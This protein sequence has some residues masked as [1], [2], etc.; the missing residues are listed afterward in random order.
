M[1][2]KQ[3][4]FNNTT[5]FINGIAKFRPDAFDLHFIF[6]DK[7][8]F[9][10]SE[11]KK[12][13]K[14]VFANATIMGC[15][16]AGEIDSQTV[17]EGSIVI[18]SIKFKNIKIIKKSYII[19]DSSHSK[20][21]GQYLAK[22]LLFTGLKHI[23]VLSDGINVNGTRLTEGINEMIGENINVSGGLAGDNG[24]FVKTYV[25]DDN[26]NFVSNCI[27]AIG[28]YEEDI[29]TST[30]AYGGWSSFGIERSITKSIENKVYE[31]DDKPALKL[32]KSYLGNLANYLPQSA[33]F[34][35]LELKE[36]KDSNP[37]VRTVLGVNKKEN[38]LT[39]AGNI[40]EGS[41][42][43]LMKTNF[44]H[45][46]NGAE[47]AAELLSNQMHL[48]ELIIVISCVGRK[49]VLKQLTQDEI[50]AIKNTIKNKLY[51]T[52]FYSYGEISK[53]P[54]SSFCELHNQ[55]MTLTGF[56]ETI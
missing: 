35:P 12:I 34:F 40:P 37:L 19:N 3:L 47:R 38:T 46:I 48:I 17:S 6:A 55:T 39:F 43:K 31:I 36:R 30:A 51:I 15:S 13:L 25:A 56:K 41:K 11:S 20:S 54:G 23:F 33:L 50:D 10:D 16:T 27:S 52:G 18:T 24:L 4:K 21:A 8:Y 2:I 9:E 5:D 32:Y 7:L 14:L 45:V 1:K 29:I 49:M 42:V 53:K 28:F 44:S 26:N 22:E